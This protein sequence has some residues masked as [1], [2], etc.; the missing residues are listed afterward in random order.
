M[1]NTKDIWLFIKHLLKY[2]HVKVIL[3]SLQDAKYYQ[4]VSVTRPCSFSQTGTFTG[5]SPSTDLSVCPSNTHQT[6]FKITGS[7][8]KGCVHLFVIQLVQWL[9][10]TWV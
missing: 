9:C 2:Q 1:F 10:F 6:G 8:G 7:S 3:I 4:T 5:T